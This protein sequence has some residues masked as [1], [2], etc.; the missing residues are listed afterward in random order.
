MP[1]KRDTRARKD[2]W[3]KHYADS[4]DSITVTCR[5]LDVPPSTQ[6]RWSREDDVFR[7]KFYAIKGARKDAKVVMGDIYDPERKVAAR[8]PFTEWR[9]HY[10]GRQVEEHQAEL[11]EAFDD[12]TNL[13]IFMFGPPGMGKD[14]TAGDL[15]LYEIPY[16]RS[17]R[18][19][20][21]MKGETFSKRRVAE[22]LDPYLTDQNIYKYQ[23]KGAS[24]VKPEGSLIADVGPFKWV[25]G[26]TYPDGT[27][28][29]PTT[30]NKSE[31]YLLGD[32]APEADPNFWATGIEGQ[33]YGS[34][35]DLMVMSDVF[36]RENQRNP[37]A[38]LGQYEWVM[39]TALSRLDDRGRLI[40]LGTRALPD[41][42]YGKLMGTF[43]GESPVVHQGK[44]YT[45]YA[46]GVATIII[47]AIQHDDNG[48]EKSYWPG[49][50]PLESYLELPDGT[51]YLAETLTAEELA[52]L[53]A[54]GA[55]RIRGLYEI[56][57][58]DRELFDTMY[59]QDPPSDITGD[60]TDAVLDRPDDP[61][62]TLGVYRPGE[63]LVV[64]VD[65]A[66][67]AGAAWVAWG[68][69]RQEETITLVDYGFYQ[70]LGISGIKKKLV[71]HPITL[72][73]PIYFCYET[74]REEAVL[75]DPTISQVFNDFGV[76]VKRH[77]TNV[78]NRSSMAKGVISVPAMSQYMRTGTIRW[79]TQTA[80]DRR[81]IDL[82]KTHFK[83][84]DR[85]ELGVRT[86]SGSGGHAP[87]DIAMAAWVGFIQ[88]LE[89]L[90]G[91]KRGRLPSAPVP[92]TIR[93]KW[94]RVAERHRTS[95]K[96]KERESLPRQPVTSMEELVSMTLTAEE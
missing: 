21:I 33:M 89:L 6:Q 37:T 26:M 36:D 7:T 18:S 13:V 62:R 95:K 92:S 79:P 78:G 90:T 80:E 19:A 85:R 38:R 31:I 58:R 42:N 66:R 35:V 39:G 27:K 74:N 22:R 57:D 44:H 91:N 47:P 82:V 68:V 29:D 54:R 71:I 32:A 73:D 20:W 12:Q 28:I 88:A 86:R 9:P 64:G 34:R 60:F 77:N 67:R 17:L 52:D 49:K 56:R 16:D 83:S 65:P 2:Q 93:R 40:V 69:N 84:W 4:G 53:A 70:N 8:L 76:T 5:L 15:L 87:D 30:W 25:K 59:Q 63:L 50:F 96:I 23:P 46:N 1:S 41:D 24:S 75:D 81:K 55:E 14:T 48:N 61:D 45:K 94:K 51:R 3:L 43:I 11:V 10:L 72:Y